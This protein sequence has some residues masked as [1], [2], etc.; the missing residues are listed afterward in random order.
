MPLV[1]EQVYRHQLEDAVTY[2][3]HDYVTWEVNNWVTQT[4]NIRDPQ[5]IQWYETQS[6]YSSA[7]TVV[8]TDANGGNS[9]ADP[10]TIQV[11]G[12]YNDGDV[13]QIDGTY[14][15]NTLSNVPWTASVTV[16]DTQRAERTA[17][18]IARAIQQADTSINASVGSTNSTTPEYYMEVLVWV[19]EA[20]PTEGVDITITGVTY[21]PS[22]PTIPA[23]PT[24]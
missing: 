19:N 21:T 8:V 14:N 9:G 7:G 18:D 20:V 12:G 15:T 16:S 10:A 2:M 17:S 11:D 6:A 13:I 24:V 23:P 22:N 1:S 3:S 4:S 5:I